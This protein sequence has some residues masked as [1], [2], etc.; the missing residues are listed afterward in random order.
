LTRTFRSTRTFSPSHSLLGRFIRYVIGDRLRGEALFIL[1]ITTL[2]MGVLIAH[3]LGWALLQPAMDA[4][5][6]ETWELRFW[7]AQ[8]GSV[9]V[10]GLLGGLGWR[11]S[12]EATI[13]TDAGT[14]HLSQGT[15]SA[16]V[17]LADIE[18]VSIVSARLYHLHYRHYANT[19]PFI[20]EMTD[21]IIIIRSA[22][23][24]LAVALGDEDAGDLVEL[25]RPQEE[26][27]M[28]SQ[29]AS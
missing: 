11:P 19:T 6:P 5:N 28:E 16:H 8:I 24:P 25:V 26:M 27:V 23:G 2:L 18:D 17:E 3:Y 22:D 1:T 7:F 29:A 20:G 12:V 21:E 4:S 13:D 15:A 9:L 10:L 14:L